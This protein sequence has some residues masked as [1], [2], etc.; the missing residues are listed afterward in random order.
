MYSNPI[1]LS[2]KVAFLKLSR[3]ILKLRSQNQ[4][5]QEEKTEDEELSI[6]PLFFTIWKNFYDKRGGFKPITKRILHQNKVL[7]SIQELYETKW[8]WDEASTKDEDAESLQVC[9]FLKYLEIGLPLLF[10]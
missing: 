4:P 7:T 8:R 2:S 6:S 9:S 5:I 1:P 3:P 10:S